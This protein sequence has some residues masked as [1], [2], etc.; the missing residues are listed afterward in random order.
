MSNALAIA[1]VTATLQRMLSSNTSGLTANLPPNVPASL[2]LNN[3]SVTTKPPDKAR[4]PN[5]NF[6]QVNLFLYQTLPNAAWRNLDL[7]RQV[8][9]GESGQ[10]PVALTLHYLLSAYS[11]DDDDTAGHVL[12][13]QALRIF[14]DQPLL[15]RNDIRNALAGND[16]YDQIESVRI[17]P[18]PLNI[19]EISKLW[20]AFQTQYRVSAAFEVSV[21]LIE[22]LRPASSPLPVLKRGS[23]DQGVFAVASPSPTIS[24]VKP[25]VQPPDSQPAAE[26]GDDLII[27]GQNPSGDGLTVRF[28]R[29][30]VPLPPA[31]PE[32]I[33][34][35][36][37][38]G[39]DENEIK[40]TLPDDSSAMSQWAPGLYTVSLVVTR[41]N[42]PPWV[43]NEVPLALAPGMTVSPTNAV[44]G[45]VTLTV[46][47]GPRLRDGQRVRLLFGDR[48]VL[49]QNIS[50]PG[51]PTQPTV[52]TFLV[53][54]TTAGQY[55]VRLRVDGVDSLPIV[56]MGTPP[57]L[58]FD[59]NQT[60][61]IA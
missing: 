30:P 6:N 40:V 54:G 28:T 32:T 24:S 23:Q 53:P 55:V 51:D 8:R 11:K 45:D 35:T 13:G 29:Q 12:L 36:P 57:V 39:G 60:V 50:N 25:D 18:Q 1:A 26:L 49:P 16:L 38:A 33:D 7:P 22:S 46:T 21:V 14:H 5:D 44:P 3:V 15:N 34:L 19:E 20:T 59:P 47:C 61:T 31:T 42:L 52:L 58:G 41:P 17:T 4:G 27:A 56:R 10:P 37:N 2:N 48:Q 9:P 43:T